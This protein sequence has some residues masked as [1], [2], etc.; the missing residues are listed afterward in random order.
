MNLTALASPIFGRPFQML[1]NLSI[2]AKITLM[3]A[4]AALGMGV[5]S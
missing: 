2:K 1:S 5:I 3:G 4:A